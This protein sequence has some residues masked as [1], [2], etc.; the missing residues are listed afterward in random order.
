MP[1]KDNYLYGGIVNPLN[2]AKWCINQANKYIKYIQNNEILMYSIIMFF[3][4]LG[5]IPLF[6][7]F[8]QDVLLKIICIIGLL[9]IFYVSLHFNDRSDQ[10]NNEIEA[11]KKIEKIT[12]G[13]KDE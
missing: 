11:H 1:K 5:S 6:S 4:F 2:W 10:R 3:I 12:R 8:I 7:Y 9:F 13:L